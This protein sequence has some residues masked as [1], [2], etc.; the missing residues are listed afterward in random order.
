[1]ARAGSVND[2]LSIV[3]QTVQTGPWLTLEVCLAEVGGDMEL[4]EQHWQW[5]SECCVRSREAIVDS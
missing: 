4:G 5:W 3:C 2:V 1:M